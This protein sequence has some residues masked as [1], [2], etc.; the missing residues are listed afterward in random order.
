VTLGASVAAPRTLP[1]ALT[2]RYAIERKLGEGGMGA[3]YL[4][5]DRTLD[6]PV[7]IK[8]LPEA[9]AEQADLRERFLRE[10]R[11]AASFSH[12][13]IVP[14]YA[15][16]VHD[17]LLAYAMGF[18]EGETV[19]ERVRRTGALAVREAVRL[20]TDVAYALAYAHARGIVHRDIKPD[21][22]MLERETGRALLMDFGIARPIGTET[23]RQG[24]TRVGEVVGTPEFMSPEQATG[25]TVD[26]R[27]DLY[28]LGLVAW[29][30]LAGRPAIETTSAQQAIVA[31]LTKVVPRLDT[32]R[33]GLP[34]ALV[35]AVSR[36]L[37]KDP[38]ARFADAAALIDAAE[39]AGG[40][41]VPV[42]IRLLYADLTAATFIT[43]F[44]P[45]AF[46]YGLY[47]IITSGNGNSL[48]FG[49]APMGILA[50]R[51]QQAA[52]EI[53]LL[54]AAGFSADDIMGH[55]LAIDRE[56]AEQRALRS[57][58][59]S[60]MQARRREVWRACG[61]LT[62]ALAA[63]VT[64]IVQFN[65]NRRAGLDADL[66]DVWAFGFFGGMLVAAFAVTV[67]VR[68]PFRAGLGERVSRA[69][70]LGPPGRLLL[71]VA[72]A[73]RAAPLPASV[74]SAAAL[75]SPGAVHDRLANVEAR[76]AALEHWR[77]SQ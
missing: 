73:G 68:S 16:E 37:E 27:S 5:H 29:Y 76:L 46:S 14:V 54:R 41:D 56:R 69:L 59:P 71:R 55:W 52:Q 6:R 17:D 47:R 34:S 60:V 2:S 75:P 36:C 57:A 11:L 62:V 77:A 21:N 25:D 67:L 42:P 26:G 8:V 10:T 50:V 39:G 9:F 35:E 4:A 43:F 51:L 31:Q 30:A 15:V 7:A 65:A 58:M 48:V 18:V 72:G 45:V 70:W 3:V 24:L 44:A 32:I 74:P 63:I 19:A 13:N 23:G 53:R 49:A 40:R 12:P 28:S 61:V 22:I 1:S 38:A 33:T 66:S 64:P 20:L